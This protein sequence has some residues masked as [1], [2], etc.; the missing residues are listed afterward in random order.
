MIVIIVV[1]NKLLP[2]SNI[3]IACM[4]GRVLLPSNL[5]GTVS[6]VLISKST[7]SCVCT[8]PLTINFVKTTV[9]R[10]RGWQLFVVVFRATTNY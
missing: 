4:V 10:V 1:I 9:V 8:G 3:A 2:G 6:N 5:Q 7:P